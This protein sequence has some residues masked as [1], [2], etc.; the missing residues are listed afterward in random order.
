ML[1]I[2]NLKG[3][4]SMQLTY[5]Q[6][7]YISKQYMHLLNGKITINTLNERLQNYFNTTIDFT[8]TIN[9][10]YDFNKG[11]GPIGWLLY[12]AV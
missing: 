2:L 1:Y 7:N 4:S 11:S 9:Y 8:E 3:W 10:C 12:D 6:L 5:E